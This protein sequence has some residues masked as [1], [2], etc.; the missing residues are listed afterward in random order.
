MNAAGSCQLLEIVQKRE[1]KLYDKDEKK[2]IE[3]EIMLSMAERE[4]LE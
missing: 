1:E 4:E 2:S 3:M